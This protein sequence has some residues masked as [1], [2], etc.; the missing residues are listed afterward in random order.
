MAALPVAGLGV[1]IVLCHMHVSCRAAEEFT[2][3]CAS[4]FPEGC[5]APTSA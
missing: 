2:T 4:S 5:K 3:S 1:V